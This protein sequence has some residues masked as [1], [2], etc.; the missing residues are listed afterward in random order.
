MDNIY[1]INFTFFIFL[2]LMYTDKNPVQSLSYTG[3]KS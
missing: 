2:V 3:S 1:V